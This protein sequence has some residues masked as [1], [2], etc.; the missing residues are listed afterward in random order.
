MKKVGSGGAGGEADC[1]DVWALVVRVWLTEC[2]LL[3]RRCCGSY[4]ISLTIMC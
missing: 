3:K 4:D 1:G 2:G